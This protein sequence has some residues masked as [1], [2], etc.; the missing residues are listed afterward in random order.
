M[1]TKDNKLFTPE[2]WERL[3][4]PER[5]DPMMQVVNPRAWLP[6]STIGFLLIVATVWSVVGRIPLTVT[7]QGVLIRPRNIVQFQA[8]SAGQLLNLKIKPGDQVKK[9][10]EIAIIDQSN[11]KQQLEQEK[12]KLTQL[13]WQN[14]NS[15]RLQKQ[16]IELELNTLQQQQLDLE[17]SLRRESVTPM[18]HQQMLAALE[19]K[20][21]SLE[22]SLEREQIA[23]VLHQQAIAALEQKRRSLEQRKQ[24]LSAMLQTLQQRYENH[25]H[26]FEVEK[27]ISQD[28]FLQAKREFLETETQISDRETE[29]KELDVQKTNT[30]Q[31]YLQNLNKVN[32]IKNSIQQV[33]VEKTNAERQYLQTLNNIDEIKT[34]IKQIEAEKAKLAQQNLEKKITQT[35]QVDEIQRK[36][37]QLELQ[38]AKDSKV[39]SQYEGR[40]LE[41]SSVSGQFVNRGNSLGSMEAENP[42]Q[43]M[44]SVVYFSDQDG[45]QIKPGMKVQVTPSVVKRERYGGIVGT[46]TQVSPF[47][48]TKQEMSV[49]IGNESLANN[50]AESVSNQAALVQ[51]FVELEPNQSN[52]SGYQWSSSTGPSLQISAGTTAQVRVQIGQVAP[53]SYVIPILRSWTGIYEY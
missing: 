17:Q 52:K 27:A 26:L 19:Q 31:E 18:L 50:L 37:A 40:I 7:G 38:L 32:E 41:L 10:Q 28:L 20:R 49:L 9:G 13:E 44:V 35:N 5:L 12:V 25:R 29:L 30:D 24:N 51:V 8:P 6:L 53:I 43:K 21:Q 42:A 48:V 11:L 46:V 34:K 4:S 45:K 23:P 15:D 39:I 47:P 14:Q 22:E 1:Q 3:S 36:I 2:A 33:Q 16:Q